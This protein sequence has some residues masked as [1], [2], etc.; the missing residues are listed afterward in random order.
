MDTDRGYAAAAVRSRVATLDIVIAVVLATLLAVP[1]A[2][3]LGI[4]LAGAYT[5]LDCCIPAPSQT[6]AVPIFLLV[7]GYVAGR[8]V[9]ALSYAPIPPD[10]GHRGIGYVMGLGTVLPIL[11]PW[12]LL[13]WLTRVADFLS[14][15]PDQISSSIRATLDVLAMT[16][17]HVPLS[18]LLVLLAGLFLGSAHAGLL[19]ARRLRGYPT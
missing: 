3:V 17:E 5:F 7:G 1:N 11:I 10:A 16:G 13:P 6:V 12:L 14:S 8:T 2:A 15:N 19:L 18:V 4:G 9:T